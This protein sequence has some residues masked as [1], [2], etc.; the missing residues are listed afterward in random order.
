MTSSTANT[1]AV[2]VC[3]DFFGSFCGDDKKNKDKFQQQPTSIEKYIT[4]TH[5]QA[6]PLS[7][8]YYLLAYLQIPPYITYSS[9]TQPA[10]RPPHP[11]TLPF[12]VL[13]P[14]TASLSA[15]HH[16]NTP[17]TFFPIPLFSLVEYELRPP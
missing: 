6:P 4:I 12:P 5:S 3:L 2:C 15:Y 11:A 10:T 17:A 14:Y 1:L 13:F 16:T 8:H 7:H 9:H